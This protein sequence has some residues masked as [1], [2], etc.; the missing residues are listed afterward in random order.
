MKDL[1]LKNYIIIFG[2]IGLL[3]LLF[4]ITAF[5][6]LNVSQTVTSGGTIVG[7]NVGVYSDSTC[8]QSASSINWGN[9][10]PGNS[11]NF[12]LWIK[13]TGRS[14]MTLSMTTSGWSPSN[15]STGITLSWNQQNTLLTPNQIVQG[16]LTLTVSPTISTSVTTFNFTTTITGTG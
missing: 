1:K 6:A 7:V 15:A 3:V 14:S 10:Q 4:A 16:L 11:A 8:T 13:N 2:A 9:L 12:T 5:G